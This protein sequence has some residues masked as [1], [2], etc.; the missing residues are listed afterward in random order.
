MAHIYTEEQTSYERHKK[1]YKNLHN[2]I[3]FTG[4][5][6]GRHHQR[7]SWVKSGW[8]M[9]KPEKKEEYEH[10]LEDPCKYCK[11]YVAEYKQGCSKDPSNCEKKQKQKL[12]IELKT[13]LEYE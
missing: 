2:S 11:H 7:D 9:I 3:F 13:Y 10:A 12:A 6:A 8:L 5:H 1:N 4:Y